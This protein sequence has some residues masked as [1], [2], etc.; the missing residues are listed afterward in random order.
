MR[1]AGCL[2]TYEREPEDDLACLLLFRARSLSPC[3][4]P[5]LSSSSLYCKIKKKLGIGQMVVCPIFCLQKYFKKNHAAKSVPENVARTSFQDSPGLFLLSW[6]PCSCCSRWWLCHPH[7]TGSWL[8]PPCHSLVHLTSSPGK[9]LPLPTD[10]SAYCRTRGQQKRQNKLTFL[11]KPV[12]PLLWFF[13]RFSL[14]WSG[15]GSVGKM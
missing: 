14:V 5:F 2:G 10:C 6:M 15:R 1:L 11:A 12:P 13:S 3:V 9:H 8:Q 4:R 7:Q